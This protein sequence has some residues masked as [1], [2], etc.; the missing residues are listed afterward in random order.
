ML[1]PKIQRKSMFPST[2]AHP[3]CMKSDVTNVSRTGTWCTRTTAGVPSVNVPTSTRSSPPGHRI[4]SSQGTNPY[5]A[6]T[7]VKPA[8]RTGPRFERRTWVGAFC[9]HTKTARLA[10]I[11]AIVRIGRRRV[12]TLS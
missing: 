9:D 5:S 11:S 4:V 6:V 7:A 1:F 2:C 8:T 10:T 12:G 3:P